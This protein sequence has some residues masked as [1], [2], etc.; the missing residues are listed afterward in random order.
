[1]KPLKIPLTPSPNKLEY[2]LI[3]MDSKMDYTLFLIITS[4]GKLRKFAVVTYGNNYCMLGERSFK[5]Y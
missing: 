3:N 1:M 5:V 4:I 2:C